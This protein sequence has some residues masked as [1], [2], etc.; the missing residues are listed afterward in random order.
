MTANEVSAFIH[1]ASDGPEA[2]GYQ[3]ISVIKASIGKEPISCEKD[4]NK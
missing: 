2:K 1:A 4:A 3:G